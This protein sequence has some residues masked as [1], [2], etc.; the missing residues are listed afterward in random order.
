[1]AFFGDGSKSIPASWKQL[2]TWPIFAE[3]PAIPCFTTAGAAPAEHGERA[4]ACDCRVPC[5]HLRLL[6]TMRSYV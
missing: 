2:K 5:G 4:R 3:P 1:M 6:S